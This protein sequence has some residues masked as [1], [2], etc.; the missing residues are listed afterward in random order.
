VPIRPWAKLF[1]AGGP[2]AN[3]ERE[4]IFADNASQDGTVAI[5]PASRAD[6]TD[7]TA[8][9]WSVLRGREL[10][11]LRTAPPDH[12]SNVMTIAV[13]PIVGYL[14][15]LYGVKEDLPIR[16]LEL[17]YAHTLEQIDGETF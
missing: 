10:V 4:H 1:A 15:S 2:L 17:A 7:R 9:I 16:S 12:V 8:R 13:R 3:Y 14:I 6:V 11:R 5:L